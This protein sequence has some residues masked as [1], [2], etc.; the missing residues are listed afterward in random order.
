MLWESILLSR[1][2]LLPTKKV[3]YVL[4]VISYQAYDLTTSGTTLN[5]YIICH[6][7]KHRE[8]AEQ[9]MRLIMSKYLIISGD[10]INQ[11]AHAIHD[12]KVKKNRLYMILYKDRR[13]WLG[14][15][16]CVDQTPVYSRFPRQSPLETLICH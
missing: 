2:I 5:G 12:Y 7:P 3:T 6:N 10:S 14:C 8:R 13:G 16:F 9:E 4:R 1:V 11:E 15:L